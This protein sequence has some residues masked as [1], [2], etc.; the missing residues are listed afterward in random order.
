MF[1]TTNAIES[2]HR[3]IRLLVSESGLVD[4]Q[5]VAGAGGGH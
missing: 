4:E 3:R 2:M 1:Y 5:T